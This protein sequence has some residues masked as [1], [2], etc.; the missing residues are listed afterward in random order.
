M[1]NRR[2]VGAKALTRTYLLLADFDF[3]GLSASWVHIEH[4]MPSGS[5]PTL[6]ISLFPM[7]FMLYP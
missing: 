3:C 1:G 5:L 4:S 7:A 6:H 2:R